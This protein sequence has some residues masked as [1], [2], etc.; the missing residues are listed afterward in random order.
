[1]DTDLNNKNNDLQENQCTKNDVEYNLN[2][3][4]REIAQARQKKLLE[5]EFIRRTSNANQLIKNEIE[6]KRE[7]IE[8]LLYHSKQINKCN[9]IK[10]DEND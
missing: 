4:A 7:A 3:L 10:K 9:D 5:E 2:H 1:M 8:N 6:Q